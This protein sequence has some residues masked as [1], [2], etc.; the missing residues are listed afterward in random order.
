M[1]C[2]V[3]WVNSENNREPNMCIMLSSLQTCTLIT[4]ITN[5]GEVLLSIQVLVLLYHRFAN[6]T[7]VSLKNKQVANTRHKLTTMQRGIVGSNSLES[8]RQP[9]IPKSHLMVSR[10]LFLLKSGTRFVTR[11]RN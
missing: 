1:T 2:V 8:P 11:R 3:S 4:M 10:R 6:A 7:Q 9:N 5:V